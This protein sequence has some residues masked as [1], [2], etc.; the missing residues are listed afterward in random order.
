MGGSIGVDTVWKIIEGTKAF[1]IATSK[2]EVERR[3]TYKGDDRGARDFGQFLQKFIIL[4]QIPWYDW[5]IDLAIEQICADL[6]AEEID[7]CDISFSIDK[8]VRSGIWKITDILPFIYQS[9]TYHSH[10]NGISIGLLLSLAYH[11]PRLM[12]LQTASI[13]EDRYLA[14]T[15]T[16][17]DLVGDENNFSA[18]FYK[19]IIAKW[20]AAGKTTRAHVGEL[21]GTGDNVRHAIELGVDRIAHGIKG[22]KDDIERATDKGISFDLALSSNLYTG[23]VKNIADHPMKNMIRDGAIVTLNTDDPVQFGCTLDS[24]YQLALDSHLAHSRD[25][26]TFQENAAGSNRPSYP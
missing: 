13:V 19:P 15:V 6:K 22:A 4:D 9:F 20:K 24:E 10:N 23:A 1:H 26:K 8:Y 12:Q 17:I 16:G 21:D 11:A 2:A 14:R 3:M 5:A 25:L 18:E 7:H